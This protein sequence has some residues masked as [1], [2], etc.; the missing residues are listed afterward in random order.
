MIM[1]GVK[2]SGMATEAWFVSEFGWKAGEAEFVLE[3]NAVGK[4]GEARSWWGQHQEM[5][6]RA[7]LVGRLRREGIDC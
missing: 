5:G 4:Q 3:S 2:Q 7:A 6:Q 1:E